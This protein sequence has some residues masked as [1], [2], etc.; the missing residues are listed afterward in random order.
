[1]PGQERAWLE[2]LARLLLA[3]ETHKLK[4]HLC[5]RYILKDGQMVFGWH[6]QIDSPNAKSVK[7]QIEPLLEVLKAAR[8]SLVQEPV[9]AQSPEPAVQPM[10]RGRPQRPPGTT[11]HPRSPNEPARVQRA[12]EGFQPSLT[13]VRDDVDEDGKRH[14]EQEFPL[15]HVFREMNRPNDKDRGARK[16]GG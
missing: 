16:T 4:V 2:T 10:P 15:P 3:A 14:I 13:T 1:M 6:V 7:S 12:P 8:P 5:R 11:A 9:A